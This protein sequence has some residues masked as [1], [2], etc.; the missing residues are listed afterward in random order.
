MALASLMPVRHRVD[1]RHRVGPHPHAEVR[2]RAVAHDQERAAAVGG[3]AGGDHRDDVGVVGQ[4]RHRVG[5]GGEEVLLAVG[6]RH[7]GSHDLDRD[8]LARP[9]LLVEE[10]VGEAAAAQVLD[11]REPGDDRGAHRATAPVSKRTA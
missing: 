4:P 1:G 6:Q 2:R 5:L 7:V 3:D 11:E 9:L 10:D 8:A